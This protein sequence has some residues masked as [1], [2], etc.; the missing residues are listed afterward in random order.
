M[1]ADIVRRVVNGGHEC[2]VYDHNPDAVKAMAGRT[3]PPGCPR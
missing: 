2:V 1:G 3:T